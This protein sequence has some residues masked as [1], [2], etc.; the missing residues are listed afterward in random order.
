MSRQTL[1]KI[2]LIFLFSVS[3]SFAL[4]RIFQI[5]LT[6]VQNLVTVAG[7]WAPL[8]YCLV[9]FLG[10]TVPFNPMSD[11]ITVSLAALVFPPEVAIAMTFIA[12]S[13]ALL[14]NYSISRTWGDDL[15]RKILT[16]EEVEKVDKLGPKLHIGWIF[17]FRF[18]LPLNTVG[19]DV[20]S[21]GAGIAKIDF[22]KFYLASI[23]PWTILNVIFFTSSSLLRDIHPILIFVPI[24]LLILLPMAYFS[25]KN[26]ASLTVTAKEVITGKKKTSPD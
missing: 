26:R 14:V 21:Y 19:I 8:V 6:D 9:L 16:K 20:I 10:L 4:Q 25:Y 5:S 15:L 13:L 2:S 7:V 11:S 22:V 24:A 17:G 18:L 12:H 23:I 1:L 3:L